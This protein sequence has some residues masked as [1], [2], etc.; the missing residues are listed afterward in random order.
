MLMP[1]DGRI[2]S[3]EHSAL[4]ATS[5]SPLP[6]F[7]LSM[8]QKG[9]IVSLQAIPLACSPGPRSC[10]HHHLLPTP[11]LSQAHQRS[12]SVLCMR[13]LSPSLP[14]LLPS[15]LSYL[16]VCLSTCPVVCLYSFLSSSL[17]SPPPTNLFYTGS[18]A[19]CNFS[20]VYLGSGPP[21]ITLYLF[22]IS[23]RCA[24]SMLLLY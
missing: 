16:F 18:V 24:S 22:H 6:S 15:W 14:R 13:L 1:Q 3:K 19:W 8:K 9:R 11:K 20:A 4:I 5:I 17:P 7:S 2:Q 23:F 21:K 10:L 12:R